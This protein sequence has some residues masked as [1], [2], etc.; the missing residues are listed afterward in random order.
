MSSPRVTAA[1]F[2]SREGQGLPVLRV[3][4][5]SYGGAPASDRRLRHTAEDTLDKVRPESLKA[6]G[7][8]LYHALDAVEAE[9][10]RLRP[11]GAR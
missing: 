6:V 5:L 7:D 8:V 10:K 9:W 2:P 1:A 11:P 4:D 3:A